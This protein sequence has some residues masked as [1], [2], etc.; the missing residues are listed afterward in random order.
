MAEDNIPITFPIEP[1]AE[2]CGHCGEDAECQGNHFFCDHC[3]KW[4]D[5]YGN[6]IKG[7]PHYRANLSTTFPDA[8]THGM[9]IPGTNQLA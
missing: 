9:P 3:G 1:Q 6:P 5:Q 2:M 4:S 8:N 7:N